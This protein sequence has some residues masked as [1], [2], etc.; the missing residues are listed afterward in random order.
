MLL[1]L[2]RS[3]FGRHALL[4]V[5]LLLLGQIIGAV[6]LHRLVFLP[7]VAHAAALVARQIGAVHQGLQ[8]LPVSQRAA[9]VAGHNSRVQVLRAQDPAQRGIRL[10]LLD[11]EF[12]RAFAQEMA[13]H[14]LSVEWQPE[15][16]EPFLVRIE[17]DGH[18]HAL[19]LSSLVPGQTFSGALIA[20]M[21]GSTLLA[22]LAALWLQ[23]WLDRPL[24]RV[25]RAAKALAREQAPEPLPEN[26]PRE[27]ATVSR[28]FNRL[29]ASLAATD[30]ERTIMLAGISHDLRTPLTKM[31]LGLEILQDHSRETELLASLSRSVDEM[32]EVVGQFLA[33]ARSDSVAGSALGTLDEIAW[34]LADASAADG[35]PLLLRQ[36]Q[37]SPWLMQSAAL[38]RA[39]RNLV[40][41]AWKHGQA[42]VELRTFESEHDL[43]FE[44]RDH[45]PGVPPEELSRLCLPFVRGRRA[46]GR[47]AGT[48]LGLAIADRI[49][50][51]HGGRLE[52]GCPPEGGLQVR[53]V[54]ARFGPISAS[55]PPSPRSVR[56]APATPSRAS[57]CDRPAP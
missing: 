6:L 26:G 8:A 5:L 7:R 51:R 40:D 50:R 18:A 28:S 1:R 36:A 22:L 55:S 48:G 2:P 34:R 9:F 54:F 27:I 41:N 25:V 17:L 19:S 4:L 33:F 13:G 10:A 53:A 16:T 42:P 37:D 23:R 3:L 46:Q 20:M 14:G 45:G 31:R 29:V 44:V 57:R 38:S 15:R 12:I 49:V 32:D 56:Q 21:A 43:G 30:R 47:V 52:L 35:R 11:R 24:E 39:M